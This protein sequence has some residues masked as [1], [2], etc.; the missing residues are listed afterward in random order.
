MNCANA[1]SDFIAARLTDCCQIA[2]IGEATAGNSD[3]CF[4]VGLSKK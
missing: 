3:F 2:T 4:A 1:A